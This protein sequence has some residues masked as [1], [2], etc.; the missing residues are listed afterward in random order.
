MEKQLKQHKNI[1]D[2]MAAPLRLR[3]EW[4]KESMD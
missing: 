1:N 4:Y 2:T 3:N